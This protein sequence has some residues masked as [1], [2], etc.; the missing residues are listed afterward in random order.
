MIIRFDKLAVLLI[1]L[2]VKSD[3]YPWDLY[4]NLPEQFTYLYFYYYDVLDFY[5]A[6]IFKGDSLD[7]W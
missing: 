3:A 1:L 5:L 4:P 7:A 6:L 2:D